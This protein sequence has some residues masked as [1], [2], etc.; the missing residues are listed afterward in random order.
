MRKLTLI[1]KKIK[2]CL[3]SDSHQ[4]AEKHCFH[5]WQEVTWLKPEIKHRKD[6]FREINPIQST[7]YILNDMAKY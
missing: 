5:Q 3:S 4:R 7:V 2:N 6:F 1:S